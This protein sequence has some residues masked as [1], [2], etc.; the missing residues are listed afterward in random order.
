[1]DPTSATLMTFGS[2]LLAGSWMLL[3]K[4][5]FEAD[6]TWGL[7]TLFLPPVAYFYGLFAWDK[8][9]EAII[10]SVMGWVLIALA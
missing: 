1:M 8:A 4:E 5:S 9:K 7:S 10:M 2:I 6:F 3:L